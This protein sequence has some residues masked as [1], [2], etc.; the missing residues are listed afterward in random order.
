[1]GAIPVMDFTDAITP[2]ISEMEVGVVNQW[3]YYFEQPTRYQLSAVKHAKNVTYGIRKIDFTEEERER[4][5]V[6]ESDL[7][8]DIELYKKYIHINKRIEEEVDEIQSKLFAGCRSILGITYRGTDYRNRDVTGEY[9]QPTLIDEL[10]KAEFFMNKWDCSHVFL[11]TEDASAV[12]AFK[13]RFGERLLYLEK[14]RYPQDTV[15]TQRYKF[16]R[17]A[18]EYYKAIEYF[19][20]IILLSRCDCLISGK[21]GILA[22][23]LPM[24]QGKY[25][26]KYIYDLGIHGS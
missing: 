26:H 12:S 11:T 18:D 13:E 2:N 7:A 22:L 1:M 5:L 14:Q 20:E 10:E 19:M 9:R 16:N 6:G 21:L 3:E 24:N 23:L 8:R 25:K 15:C 17:K 4:L